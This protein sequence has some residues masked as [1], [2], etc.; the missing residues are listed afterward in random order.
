M[1][2]KVEKTSQKSK[3][4][5]S[6]ATGKQQNLSVA[7]YDEI[8]R[9]LVAVFQKTFAAVCGESI[10]SEDSSDDPQSQSQSDSQSQSKNNQDGCF[11]SKIP[12]GGYLAEYWQADHPGAP[13]RSDILTAEDDARIHARE[14]GDLCKKP[15]KVI[16]VLDKD[17]NILGVAA[18][19]LR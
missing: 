13:I 8:G 16:V 18:T 5:D 12:E 2:N 7:P 4:K 6:E 19:S 11:V 14:K 10:R 17:G 15:K 9:G 3:E 1:P